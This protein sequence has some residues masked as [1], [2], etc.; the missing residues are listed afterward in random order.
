MEKIINSPEDIVVGKL[1]KTTRKVYQD[2][3]LYMGCGVR[4]TLT[5]Q[6]KFLII[7]VDE[8]SDGYYVGSKVASPEQNEG[9]WADGFI[10]QDTTH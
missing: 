6:D 10:E 2:K 5:H 9:L 7:V 8:C 4:T 1:Y 3:I